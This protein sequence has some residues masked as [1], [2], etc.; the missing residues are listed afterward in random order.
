M[1]GAVSMMIYM[2]AIRK[3]YYL[4][5]CIEVNKDVYIYRGNVLFRPV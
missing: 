5:R 2:Y 4:A 3:R 1:Y